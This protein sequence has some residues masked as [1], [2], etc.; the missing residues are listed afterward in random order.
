MRTTESNWTLR[1][2]ASCATVTLIRNIWRR[3]KE[4]HLPLR[5]CSPWHICLY[6][7]VYG[8]SYRDWTYVTLLHGLCLANRHITI[9]SSFRIN[10]FTSRISR[11]RL[12]LKSNKTSK[13]NLPSL[14]ARSWNSINLARNSSGTKNRLLKRAATSF[15]LFWRWVILYPLVERIARFEL[16]FIGVEN[17]GTTLIP[18]PHSYETLYSKILSYPIYYFEHTHHEIMF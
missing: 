7:L 1:L 12:F 13:S 5:I 11:T 14:F 15:N 18:Y 9:L 3:V 4:L 10:Y 17:R 2:W 16:V 6:Q 8:G